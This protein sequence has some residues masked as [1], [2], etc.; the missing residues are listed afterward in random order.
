MRIN[1]TVKMLGYFLSFFI[2]NAIDYQPLPHRGPIKPLE[3]RP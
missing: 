1:Q 3:D 2:Y